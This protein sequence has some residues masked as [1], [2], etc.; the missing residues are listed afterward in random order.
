MPI[1]PHLFKPIIEVMFIFIDQV[2]VSV[3]ALGQHLISQVSID[4][5]GPVFNR[6]SFHISVLQHGMVKNIGSWMPSE[7]DF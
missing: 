4:G 1:T 5:I 6:C 2:K 7:A 3:H